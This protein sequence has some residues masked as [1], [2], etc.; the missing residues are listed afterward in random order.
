MS[1][2]STEK[3]VVYWLGYHSNP[4]AIQSLPKGID[5][6]NLFLLNLATSP[7]GT[8]L[9]Y[10][11][12]TSNGTT[13]D[14]ILTQSKAAQANG[15]KVCVSII[16]PNNSLI[17]NTIPDP[18]TFAL[19]VYNL[20]KGWGL[21]G[22]DIDPEQGPGGSTPPNQ[23]FVTVVK[24]LS[25]YFGPTSNTG[26]IMSYVGYVLSSD[27]TVL[28]P[29]ASLFNY[30]MMMGYWWGVNDYTAQFNQY[31]AIVGSQNLMFGIGGDPWQTPLSVTQTLAAWEPASGNKGGM[32]EFNIN[33]DTNYQA[34]N[35]I[36]KALSSKTAATAS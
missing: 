31:A 5:V 27:E 15:V 19:N 1:T 32:M 2:T 21:D 11:Y 23:N 9:D 16:P 35:A 4:P 24:A 36:I 33:D 10:N 20:V 30:V 12:I 25:K 26:L 14:T 7:N 28:K 13:W 18:D 17:W 6:V 34:A 3:F 22:I 8:T 29:C